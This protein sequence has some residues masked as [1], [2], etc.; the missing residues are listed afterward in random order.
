[1]DRVLEKV[2]QVVTAA[3]FDEAMTPSVVEEPWSEAF[4]PWTDAPALRSSMP[5]LRRADRLRRSLVPSLLGARQTNESLANP[6]IELFEI[7]HVYLPRGPGALPSEELMLGLTS[8]GDYFAV[9]G[10][11]EGLVAALNPEAQLEVRPTRQDLFDPQRAAELRV[12]VGD[13][14]DLVLG[15]L[16]EVG[17][18][19]LKRF[20]LRGATTVAELKLSTLLEIADL[21]PQYRK[22]P[23]FPAVTRDLNLV[24]DERVRWSDVAA[25]VQKAAARCAEALRFQDVYRDPDRLGQGNKS[26]LFTLVLRSHAGTLTNDEADQIRARVVEACQA[27]HGAQLRA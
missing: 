9:K 24:V 12:R 25:T 2:R 1:M 8:G 3:G 4:S 15:Y 14:R 17:D 21:I 27:A 26:L 18:G 20:E 5:V 7:A 6:L 23:A 13:T 10:L 16:G 11:V 19:G 22:L